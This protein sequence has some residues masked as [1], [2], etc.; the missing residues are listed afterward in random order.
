MPERMNM[1]K[2]I[3]NN[4]DYY[5]TSDLGLTALLS[6]YYPIDAVNKAD[7]QK[8]QFLFEKS[9]QLDELVD[10]YWRQETKVE[11]QSY[12]NQLRFIKSRL[13]EHKRK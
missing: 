1:S 12:F 2:Q 6:L 7:S 8:V 13:Y 9:K 11:P 5:K 10:A 3:L 4:A